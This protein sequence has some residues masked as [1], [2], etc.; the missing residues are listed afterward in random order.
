MVVL[1]GF[2][3]YLAASALIPLGIVLPHELAHALTAR[4]LGA[5]HVAVEIGGPRRPRLGAVAGVELYVRPLSRSRWLGYGFARWEA[6]LS[7]KQRIAALAAGPAA[8]AVVAVAYGA[9]GSSTTGFWRY[10]CVG[11][12]IG[13]AW[14]LACTAAPITYGRFFGAFAGRRSD[15][16]KILALIRGRADE[17]IPATQ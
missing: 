2:L 5:P 14:Q 10:L 9:A 8:S 6:T 1:L 16:A 7:R 17:V 15:G 4:L 3:A 12:F 11:L 13:S